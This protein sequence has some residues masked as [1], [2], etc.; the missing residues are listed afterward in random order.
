MTRRDRMTQKAKFVLVGLAGVLAGAALT[1]NL[2]AVAREGA[3]A[4]L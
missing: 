3:G 2:S 4:G 1:V